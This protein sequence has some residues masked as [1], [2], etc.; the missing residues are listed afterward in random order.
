MSNIKI[1]VS[2]RID[3]D[4][5]LV[6]NPI[7]VPV[8][9]GAVFDPRENA[10]IQGD[11]T[12]EN[13]SRDRMSFCE[14]TVQ[15]WA[16]KNVEADYY[17]LFHYRRYLN[18]SPQEC[19]TDIYGNVLDQF[20]TK[21]TVQKYG[22]DG[23]TAEE[24][25]CDYDLILPQAQ[26]VSQY[27]EGYASVWD[28]Y[29]CAPNLHEK[30]LRLAIDIIREKYPEYAESAAAYLSGTKAQMCNLFI[31][32]KGLFFKYSQWLFDILST[33]KEQVNM[34]GYSEEEVRAP[35]HIAE[36]LLGIFVLHQQRSVSKLSIKELQP[37]VFLHSEKKNPGLAG[38]ISDLAIKPAFRTHNIPVVLSTSNKFAPFAAATMQSVIDHASPDY[39]YDIIC[40]EQE[41]TTANKRRISAIRKNDNV[42]I[43]T[44]NV[45]FSEF[46]QKKALNQYIS[47]ETYFRLFFPYLLTEYEKILWLDSDVVVQRDV[48]ELFAIDIGNL[49]V[50]A[51]R[52]YNATALLK[53][54]DP[55]YAQFCQ[56]ELRVSDAYHY[57]QA[58]V[59]LFNLHAFRQSFA[60][61]EILNQVQQYH[62]PYGDQDILNKLCRKRVYWLD[63]R[64][65]V[66]ADVDEYM[67]NF[68]RYWDPDKTYVDYQLV[69]RDPAIIHFAGPTK[70]WHSP[71]NA[72]ADQFW[73]ACRR[74]PFYEI[75]LTDMVKDINNGVLRYEVQPQEQENQPQGNGPDIDRDGRIKHVSS[76]IKIFVSH[77]IDKDSELVDNPIFVPV[78]CGAVFDPRENVAIQGDDTGEN[79][80]QRRMTFNEFTVLYWAWKNIEADYYG[81]CHYRRYMIFSPD[82]LQAD[83]YGNVLFDRLDHNSCVKCGLLD[84]V[85]MAK[86]IEGNDLIISE[87]YDVTYRGFYSLYEHYAEVSMQHREDM[88]IAL[89]VIQELYPE[90]T[91]AAKEYFNGTLFYPCN[92]FVM[93]REVFEDYCQWL[94]KL[95]FEIEKR[96]DISAYNE[97]EQRVYGL[98]GERLLGVYFTHYIKTHPDC[99]YRVI[100]RALFWDTEKNGARKTTVG[101]LIKQVLKK[102]LGESNCLYQWLRRVY[103][104]L[105]RR[106]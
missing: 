52:D 13:I 24:L 43:R 100:Q 1:F 19:P 67:S 5:E 30:D 53:G 74:T 7:F 25:I 36:R 21:E 65:D 71:L 87:P 14:L 42:S 18:F 72:M 51:T 12:G 68:L 88:A 69:K 22:L 3:K 9:C 39:N 79:I 63:N 10:A 37:V 47:T 29:V 104:V 105:D 95:L 62:Y 90:Y 85:G 54:A 80:S 2:H 6:D 32:K 58:G 75:A 73:D 101:Q 48:A 66:V 60:F 57:F 50:G 20:I 45:N 46:L 81:L 27:P 92:L 49:L 41:L 91:D 103:H 4:S 94:F 55:E 98:L 97:Q 106:N 76:N 89:D 31:M 44:F 99:K 38:A 40:I 8:R 17:G 35:G 78:R 11:D 33:F 56:N 15:Y 83:P 86:V 16:W 61:E 28:Q 82:A 59:L 84:Q 26:D 23:K 102:M 96:I 34:T 93:R 77:R 64:W 70:P